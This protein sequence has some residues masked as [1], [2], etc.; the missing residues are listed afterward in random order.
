MSSIHPTA[1]IEPGAQIGDN[2]SIGAYCFVGAEVELGD[3]VD[4][5]SHAV[6]ARRTRIGPNTHIFPFASVGH[7]PQDLKFAGESS[8]LVIGANTVIRE[9]ATLNPGTAGGGLITRV[10]NNCLIMVGAH[11]AHD[12]QIGNHVILTNN[13]TLGGHVNVAEHAIIGGMSA[14]HQ[15]VRIGAHAMVG[16]MTGVENDVIP[17]GSVVGNRAY[18]SGLNIVGLKRRGFSRDDIHRLRNAYR[19]LFAQEGTQQERMDDVAELFADSAVVMDIIAFMRA[20]SSRAMCQP[21]LGSA[22]A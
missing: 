20:D 10:G 12:C 13:A 3:G 2:V 21:K 11:V 6:V 16:G 9:H 1:I 14:V 5:K 19:L 22:T 15:F 7:Q 18:L 4:L 8:E 17:Y